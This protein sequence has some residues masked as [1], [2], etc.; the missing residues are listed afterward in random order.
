MVI[1][2]TSSA[3]S[4]VLLGCRT[5]LVAPV[6]A[7]VQGGCP[8]HTVCADL[9][10]PRARAR[11]AV[12]CFDEFFRARAGRQGLLIY[13][14]LLSTSALVQKALSPQEWH[15]LPAQ[16][17]LAGDMPF[18]CQGLLQC[19]AVGWLKGSGWLGGLVGGAGHVS[20]CLC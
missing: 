2:V 5:A 3:S 9:L 11:C 8:S 4:T 15:G 13:V 14:T 7:R 20:R 10:S 19:A 17:Y 18:A 12:L 6:G 16:Q 1:C